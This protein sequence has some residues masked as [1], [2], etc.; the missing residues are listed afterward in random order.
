MWSLYGRC[1]LHIAFPCMCQRKACLVSARQMLENE[2]STQLA[3]QLG[4]F[5]KH[6]IALLGSDLIVVK[7]MIMMKMTRLSA[8]GKTGGR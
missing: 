7:L 1:P 4:V 5:C 3:N 2:A 6:R 8:Y